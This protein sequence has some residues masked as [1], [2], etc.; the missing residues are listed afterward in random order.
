[1]LESLHRQD[2]HREDSELVFVERSFFLMRPEKVT[3]KKWRETKT[4][5]LSGDWW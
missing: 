1:M 3:L 4:N 2:A 5:I